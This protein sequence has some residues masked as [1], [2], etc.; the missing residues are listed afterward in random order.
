MSKS[1]EKLHLSLVPKPNDSGNTTDTERQEMEALLAAQWARQAVKRKNLHDA[2]FSKPEASSSSN[3]TSAKHASP[4]PMPDNSPSPREQSSESE[5]QSGE[6]STKP[7]QPK[8]STFRIAP[9]LRQ[10]YERAVQKIFSPEGR[11]EHESTSKSTDN[12]RIDPGNWNPSEN[13]PQEWAKHTEMAVEL[14]KLQRDESKK[15]KRKVVKLPTKP[16]PS[17]KPD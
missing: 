3:P 16:K 11:P 9:E 6:P 7:L 15:A 4:Q 2:V 17:G 12:A 1:S 14:L 13:D 10:S 8:H 5:T